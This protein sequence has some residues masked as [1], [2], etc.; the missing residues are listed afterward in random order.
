[1]IAIQEAYND[2]S[3]SYDQDQN[4]TRDLDQQ[5][6]RKFL[7]GSRFSAI[8]EA[9]CG[10]GKNTAFFTEIGDQVTGTD[11]SRGMLQKARL[12]IASPHVRFLISDLISPWPF[13]E[14]VFD[15]VTFSLVLEHIK[16][17]PFSF[18]EAARALS[19]GGM[20]F[21][22]ELHP[23][24]QYLGKQAVF[25]SRAGPEAALEKVQIPAYIHHL[26]DFIDAAEGSGF[27][28]RLIKE[29]WGAQDAGKPPRLAV[30][31]FSKSP[32]R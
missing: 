12:K 15:L 6:V 4:L 18:S 30:F 20:L 2:W 13:A 25:E 8:L 26:S 17:L 23:F 5:A 24:R 1:M 9:G 27:E 19:S 14:K 32:Q 3:S 7:K 16:D 11:F 29:L 31:L 21:V 28:L 10:T 22:S